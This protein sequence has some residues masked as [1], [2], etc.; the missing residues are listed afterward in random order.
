[1]NQFISSSDANNILT[2]SYGLYL[3]GTAFANT[4]D[5]SSNIANTDV[6]WFEYTKWIDLRQWTEI[7]IL[8]NMSGSGSLVDFDI[9]TS[10]IPYSGAPFVGTVSYNASD[11]LMGNAGEIIYKS[12]LPSYMRFHNYTLNGVL[13]VDP[14]QIKIFIIG[15]IKINKEEETIIDVPT[16]NPSVDGFIFTT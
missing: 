11:V 8:S 7:K 15:R 2:K 12:P 3:D 16:F 5:S 4:N 10:S 9:E 13:G 1:M 14:K 6:T